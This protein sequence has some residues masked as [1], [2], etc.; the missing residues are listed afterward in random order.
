MNDCNPFLE[1]MISCGSENIEP[2]P[3][4]DIRE[5]REVNAED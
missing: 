2:D 3:K 4:L 1:I 5:R